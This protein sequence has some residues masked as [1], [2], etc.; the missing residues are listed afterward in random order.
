M[1]EHDEPGS[2][3]DW[4]RTVEDACKAKGQ[5]LSPGVYAVEKTWVRV[6]PTRPKVTEYSVDIDRDSLREQ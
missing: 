6:R 1:S 3:R 5:D 4:H 2:G